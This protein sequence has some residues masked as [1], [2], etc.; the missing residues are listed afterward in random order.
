[1]KTKALLLVSVFLIILGLG[2]ISSGV[3]AAPGEP[4]V[5]YPSPTP[6][7]DG[8]I[9]YIVKAGDT[10][11]QISIL[12]GV[13]QDYLRLTNQLDANCSLREGQQLM[14]GVGGPA[15]ASPTPGP[16]PSPTIALPTAT[17]GAGGMAEVCV[18]VYDDVNGDGLRQ[19]T[20][21]AI[22][23]A[24]I[25]LTSLDGTYSQTLTT[26]INPDATAYQGMCFTNVPMGKYNV[27][28][29]APDGYNPT[30]NL[31]SSVDASAGDIAYIDYGAQLKTVVVTG[32]P[33]NKR[34]PLLGILGAVFLLAGIGIGVYVWSS[35]RKK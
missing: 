31:T 18:L 21:S 29:A 19:T 34:M 24:A 11:E 22:P 35:L 2:W 7:P 3:Q 12:Y 8:R 17:P 16:S 9:I 4:L 10:C 23:G 1:M 20:E 25:S 27:S 32:N 14:I 26:A 15:A 33:G 30:I 5:G 28:A 6:G 13:T